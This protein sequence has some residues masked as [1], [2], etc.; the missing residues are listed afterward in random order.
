M[1][2]ETETQFQVRFACVPKTQV[3]HTELVGLVLTCVNDTLMALVHLLDYFSVTQC[4]LDELG[5]RQPAAFSLGL[6]E[7]PLC[8]E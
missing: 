5:N 4:E 8:L 6:Y 3:S 7:F 1:A 2:P